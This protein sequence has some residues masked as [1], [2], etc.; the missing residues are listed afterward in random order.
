[1]NIL[2][3]KRKARGFHA[4]EN[5]G[6]DPNSQG[7]ALPLAFGSDAMRDEYARI[8]GNLPSSYHVAN[9]DN[10]YTAFDNGQPIGTYQQS[11]SNGFGGAL[12]NFVSAAAP[13]IAGAGLTYAGASGLGSMF[14]N[15][16]ASGIANLGGSAG[17]AGDF[18]LGATGAGVPASLPAGS[19]GSFL[20]PAAIA[21]GGTAGTSS[22]LGWQDKLASFLPSTDTL[23][24][25]KTGFDL[26]KTGMGLYGAAQNW[27]NTKTNQGLAQGIQ[28]NSQ[29]I[30]NNQNAIRDQITGINSQIAG[31]PTLASLYGQDSP[32][33]KQ[34]MAQLAAKDAA[35]G[36]NSQY[37][38]RLTNFQAQ[39][40]DKGQ[41]YATQ[42]A[43]AVGGLNNTISNLYGQSTNASKALADNAAQVAA[44]NRGATAGQAQTL[45]GLYDMYNKS[46]ISDALS[47]YFGS[48]GNTPAAMA[49]FGG[50]EG[51]DF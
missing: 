42:Y 33:A 21:S 43:S 34:L 15:G 29:D 19:V 2:D 51:L 38:Q 50:Y 25:A 5:E 45:G 46:G 35:A 13:M 31:I 7:N 32:Y 28:G 14:G 6:Y 30:I 10:T 20:D 1:M 40:A 9:A 48:G 16:A 41:Q 3:L 44:L 49:N 24:T 4:L 11:H 12:S 22:G 37:G 27:N 17:G 47:K 18:G 23:K 36:R 26:A 8:Y 39:L